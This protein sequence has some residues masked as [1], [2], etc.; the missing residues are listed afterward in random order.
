MAKYERS[1]DGNFEELLDWINTNIMN[2]SFSASYED[3]SDVTMGNIRIAVR[4]YERYSMAGGNRVS[5]NVTLTGEGDKLFISGITSGGSKA[6]FLK[7]NTAGE[8]SFL[9]ELSACVDSFI[10]RR[11]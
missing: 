11:W 8:E 4:V 6:V 7:I 10:S 9:D 1:L 2:G 5:L 3:G